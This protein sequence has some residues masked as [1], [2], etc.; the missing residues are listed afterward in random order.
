MSVIY[1]AFAFILV[2]LSL[3]LIP[4]ER[5]RFIFPV[6]L[7]STLLHSGL[8]FFLI[9]VIEAYQ[10]AG[11]EPLAIFGIPIFIVISW[12][13]SFALFLWGLP[14]NL[15]R[16]T[17]YVYIAAFA[18]TGTLIDATFHSIGLRPYNVWFS[19]WMMFF[20]LFFI[21]WLSYIIHLKRLELEKV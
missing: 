3:A 11:D 2:L 19:G 14:E 21:I 9:N 12:I 13:P 20:P 4:R 1:A 18:L 6:V 15:P 5:Y 16:W 10:Y 8:I 17:H 7:V